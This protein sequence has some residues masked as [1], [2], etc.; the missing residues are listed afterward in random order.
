MK[1]SELARAAA[2]RLE[3]GGDPEITG[4]APLD[5]AGPSDLTLFS[6][7]QYAGEAE[8]TTAGVVLVTAAL[9][10][11]LRAGLP[12]IIVDDP[13]RAL[14]VLL[15]LLHPAETPEPGVHPSA[16]I[17][18]DAV[19]GAGV[20]VGPCA[21]VHRHAQIADGVTIGAHTVI[22]RHCRIG[23][24][25]YLHP[26]VTVY[27]GVIIGARTILHSGSRIGA[28]GFGYSSS[29]AGHV[30]IPQVGGCVLGSD[31]EVG[32][33]TTIDRGSI[34]DTVIGD[35][36]KID[37]LVQVGHNVRMGEHC[38]VVSQVGLS[39][40]TRLGRFVTV[41]G[42]AA[43]RGHLSIGDGATI[44]AR[45]AVFGDVAAGSTVSG[46]PARPHREA[47]R[48]QAGLFR[49]PELMKRLRVL[50]RAVLGKDEPEK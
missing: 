7:I 17:A 23:A 8:A 32:A 42:Q 26:Q 2:G 3:G 1:A 12:R 33:N 34:G 48:A 19:L 49:L 47:M 14:T 45:G 39:G 36:C 21:V 46:Y 18:D 22:G 20:S 6:S 25:A 15:P 28:D 5:R 44:A 4:T 31:V 29:G 9:S 30:K 41:G 43:T 38:I 50:E 11:R 27:D 10:P 24:G 37:N 35:G 16:V 40:S 13:H